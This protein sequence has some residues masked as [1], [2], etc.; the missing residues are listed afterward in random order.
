[1]FNVDYYAKLYKENKNKAEFY[2]QFNFQSSYA[3]QR[4]R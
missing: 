4:D 3:I 2:F 1:M